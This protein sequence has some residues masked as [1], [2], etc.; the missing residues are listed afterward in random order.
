MAFD[1]PFKNTKPVPPVRPNRPTQRQVWERQRQNVL[2]RRRTPPRPPRGSPDFSIPTM[3]PREPRY[4]TAV[5]TTPAPAYQGLNRGRQFLRW[6]MPTGFDQWGYIN[7]F[8]YVFDRI[9]PQKEGPVTLPSGWASCGKLEGEQIPRGPAGYTDTPFI[10]GLIPLGGQH[11]PDA[12]QGARAWEEI[13]FFETKFSDPFVGGTFNGFAYRMA[14]GEQRDKPLP[15]TGGGVPIAAPDPFPEQTWIGVPR[16]R[17]G[18]RPVPIPWDRQVD[19][20]VAPDRH[21]GPTR[22]YGGEFNQPHRDPITGRPPRS[23]APPK[24][25][26]HKPPPRRTKERKGK[27]K[28]WFANLAKVAWEATEAVDI[29]DNL[30]ECLPKKVQKTAPKTGV[31]MPD[32]WQPGISYTSVIDRAKHVYRHHDKL[33][34]DCAMRKLTCNHIE[35]MLWGRFFGGV[36]N[37]AQRAGLKGFGNAASSGSGLNVTKEQKEA[38]DKWISEN[39]ALDRIRK[40]LD[41]EN[42]GRS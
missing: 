8:S 28:K 16:P 29:V 7:S 26:P 42:L 13:I 40:S 20:P 23:D 36:D 5:P 14:G 18:S 21:M 2:N 41:C 11:K 10:C 27:V 6:F 31:T 17:P 37:A 12:W 33:D 24:E 9:G 15:T 22:G 34:L 32:A 1:G 39:P 38:F 30:F 3:P 35:D 25:N 19:Q 4:G